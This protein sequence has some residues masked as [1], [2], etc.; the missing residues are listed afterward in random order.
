VLMPSATM[1]ASKCGINIK[2]CYRSRL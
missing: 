2:G 1:D